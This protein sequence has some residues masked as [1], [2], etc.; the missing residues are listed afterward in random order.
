M[1]AGPSRPAR[2]RNE[3]PPS[4]SQLLAGRALRKAVRAGRLGPADIAEATFDAV[5]TG[6]FYV[7]THPAIMESVRARHEDIEQMRAP[8]D[9]S[10]PP[11]ASA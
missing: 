3:A 1:S 4:A 5:R 11:Q 9:P 6:R 10:A 7:V 8:S 2:W